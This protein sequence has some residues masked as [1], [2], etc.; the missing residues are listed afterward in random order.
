MVFNESRFRNLILK[1]ENIEI[2]ELNI[3]NEFSDYFGIP[4]ARGIV[5]VKK[6]V[7]RFVHSR[8]FN[9]IYG[10]TIIR[11]ENEKF[12]SKIHIDPNFFTDKKFSELGKIV[13]YHELSH[14]LSAPL[15]KHF[16]NLDKYEKNT[17]LEA[18][19]TYGLVKYFIKKGWEDEAKIIT[20]TN[21][22]KHAFL[23]GYL[24]DRF[25]NDKEFIGLKRFIS[26]IREHGARKTLDRIYDLFPITKYLTHSPEV[27][28]S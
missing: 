1:S 13:F 20:V 25:Y 11:I 24:L 5:V 4:D 9:Y 26:D 7:K 28:S 8:G 16:Y 18:I 2:P 17:I 15:T 10:Q 21:S 14:V 6:P 22:H 23:F 27:V 12:I 3:M 19:A